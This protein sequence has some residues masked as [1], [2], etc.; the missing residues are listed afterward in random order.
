MSVGRLGSVANAAILP[1][2][3]DSSGLGAALLIGFCFCLFSMVNAFGLIW[4]DKKAE[5][6]DPEG[7]RVQLAEEDKFKWSDLYQFPLSYWL[8][9]GSCVVTYMSVFPYIQIASDLLQTKYH[10][11]KITAGYLF[12]VPYIIS[13]ITSPF[14][15]LGID[16][17]GKRAFLICLSSGILILAYTSSMMMTECYRCYNELYPLVLTGIG[18]SIYAAAIWGSIPYIV[19]PNTVGTAFGIT[20][21]IQNI[22]LVLAPTI[23]GHIKDATEAVDHGYFWTNVFF[24]AINV[25]GMMLNLYLYY[26]DIYHNNRVLDSASHPD[27]KKEKLQESQ[28]EE[29]ESLLTR[30]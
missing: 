25:V 23:V 11:D 4:V 12:G 15:G 26:I 8:L 20:T 13:A 28:N 6:N 29:T 27:S 10:F 7:E 2:I 1:A 14:L 9:T 3:Y 17:F 19:K 30:D 24:I 21:A 16:K 5:D 18:Y 22:G